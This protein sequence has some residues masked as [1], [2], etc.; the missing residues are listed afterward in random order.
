MN[1]QTLIGLKVHYFLFKTLQNTKYTKNFQEICNFY[2]KIK[3]NL[4]TI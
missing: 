2:L 4:Y 3:K 1:F